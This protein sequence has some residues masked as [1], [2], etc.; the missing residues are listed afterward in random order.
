M[1]TRIAIHEVENGDNWAKA[2]HKG[3][4]GRHEMFGKIGAKCRTFR[5]PKNPNLTGVIAEIQDMAA[6]EKLLASDE[7][8]KAMAED[9]LKVE[10]MRVLEEFTA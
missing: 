9:G 2:W 3:E 10:T 5:D 4:G 8:K 7:G 6:F 1:K